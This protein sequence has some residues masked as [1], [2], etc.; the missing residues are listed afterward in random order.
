MINRFLPHVNNHHHHLT[1]IFCCQSTWISGCSFYPSINHQ[2]SPNLNF[3]FFLKPKIKA[4]RLGAWNEQQQFKVVCLDSIHVS[5][6]LMPT[7]VIC[8]FFIIFRFWFPSLF[9]SQNNN[10]NK[11][12]NKFWLTH[13]HRFVTCVCCYSFLYISNVCFI[14]FFL[15]VSSIKHR[16]NVLVVLAVVVMVVVVI[17]FQEQ[18]A[19]WLV[20]LVDCSVGWMLKTRKRLNHQIVLVW[21]KLPLWTTKKRMFFFI[22]VTMMMMMIHSILETMVSLS[23][24]FIY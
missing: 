15:Y 24:L 9:Y 19:V 14:V 10:N 3:W 8:F 2:Y 21:L 4:D 20:Q 17:R 11:L 18:Q 13:T 6:V 16:K 5:Y 22:D 23:S 12:S 1:L 7:C